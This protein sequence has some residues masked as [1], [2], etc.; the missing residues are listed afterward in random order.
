MNQQVVLTPRVPK[1]R[2][3]MTSTEFD[4]MIEKGLAQAKNGKSILAEE[5]FALLFGEMDN[6]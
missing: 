1:A 6:K 5:A 4:A 2:D 3:E